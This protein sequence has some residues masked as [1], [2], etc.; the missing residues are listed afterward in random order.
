MHE[1]L[2]PQYNWCSLL[3][4]VSLFF[5]GIFP[6]IGISEVHFAPYSLVTL[7]PDAL[8]NSWIGG[9]GLWIGE[10][11]GASIAPILFLFA[12]ASIARSNNLFPKSSVVLFSI[13]ALASFL[14]LGFGWKP[15]V[16]YTSLT[17]A[18]LISAQAVLPP[19]FLGCV[20]LRMRPGITAS[21]AVAAH[22]IA[23]AWFTWSAFPW[24]GEL[25]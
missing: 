25:M 8:V 7:I 14:W 2:K 1:L 4:A 3:G 13:V 17:R 19:V 22:W 10:A 12:T 9:K 20:V 18:L 11:I 15:T 5:I 24:Y 23:L 6:L 16:E 21:G